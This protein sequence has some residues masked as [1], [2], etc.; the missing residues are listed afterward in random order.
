[1]VQEKGVDVL[2]AFELVRSADRRDADVLV[3]VSH[4]TDMEPALEAALDA[5]DV[6]IE[7]A[8][9]DRCRILRV[10]GKRIWHTRLFGQEFV[11]SRDRRD[12]A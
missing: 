1:M 2:V 9:W 5:Q 7:T 8:G 11:A 10:P 6:A 12:Y 3:Q 4:D